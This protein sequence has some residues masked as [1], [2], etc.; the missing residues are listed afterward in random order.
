[1]TLAAIPV[2]LP[3]V[4]RIPWM[5]A[6]IVATVVVALAWGIVALSG[7]SG[8]SGVVGTFHTIVPIDMD[9]TLNPKGELQAVNN[10]D[11]TNPVEGQ[12]TIID[13]AKEGDFVHKGDI[14]CKLDSTD[15]E[16]KIENATL[17]LQ[18][19]QS[20]LANAR[21]AKEIQESTNAANLEAANVDLVLTRLDLQQYVEG[22]YP[23]DLQQAQ[24]DLEMSK[25]TVKNKEDDLAQTRSLFSKGFVT[26]ADVKTAELELLKAKNDLDLKTTTLQVLQKYKHERDLTNMKNQV[27]QAEKK[28]VRTQRENASNLA[29]KLAALQQ[30]EQSLALRKQ[31]YEHLQAQL[32]ACTIKAPQDGMVVYANGGRW[33][34]RDTPIQAG[35]QSRWQELLI[36][37]PDT[38]AMKVVC[39]INEQQ[40][41]RLRLDPT[42]PVRA[43]VKL[44]SQ[45]PMIGG[46][47][48]NISI[49]PDS[50]QR[51]FT[52]SKDYP[53]DVTL[54]RTPSGLKPGMSVD[55]V[56]LFIDRIHSA[57]AVPLA[58]IYAAGDD[59]FVFVRDG[60]DVKP[61]KVALGQVNETNAALTSGITA[62][63]QVLLL[64]AGQ[65]R[66][67]LEKAGIKIAPPKPATQPALDP[68]K[69]PPRPPQVQQ[70]PAGAANGGPNGANGA[71]GAQ[72]R[73]PGT[74]RQRAPRNKD[75]GG[76]G[77]NGA[78]APASPSSHN[79]T[80]GDATT[81]P[82]KTASAN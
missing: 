53:V 82:T 75:N 43:T 23:S 42:K 27:A 63:E 25:V 8:G 28:L 80:A 13:I 52:D 20:D 12:S 1:M 70:A 71:D 47:L 49:M 41:Q 32:A 54:D 33:G 36:R 10:V 69:P 4:R 68:T 79:G 57:L 9:I 56:K 59:N 3:R 73:A 22:Q 31:Q 62:G 67:L 46:Y 60:K 30:Y 45:T 26:A 48:S 64:E 6:L 5:L 39:R 44:N 7:S 77:S 18:K 51:W 58:A 35:A 21:E 29:A 2:S 76:A 40:V 50:S 15:I 74:G 78:S 24:T 55:D 38:S 61:R 66:E 11:I 16:N 72:Q 14:V 37:L 19:A 65:G 81:R 34:G 17:D